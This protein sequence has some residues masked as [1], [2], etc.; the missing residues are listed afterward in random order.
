MLEHSRDGRPVETAAVVVDPQ[1]E[2]LAGCRDQ[3]QGIVGALDGARPLD[4][5]RLISPEQCLID[6]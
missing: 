4:P 3:G 5:Q 2:L 6:G 1:Q